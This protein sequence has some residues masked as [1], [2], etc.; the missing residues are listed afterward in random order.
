[1]SD[2]L[3]VCLQDKLHHWQ[4]DLHRT[5]RSRSKESVIA[6]LLHGQAPGLVDWGLFICEIE[7]DENVIFGE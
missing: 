7:D 1:M 6:E 5:G 4:P 3:P 2:F